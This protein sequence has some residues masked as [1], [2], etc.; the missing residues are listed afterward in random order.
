[1]KRATILAILLISSFTAFAQPDTTL[2]A[3]PEIRFEGFADIFYAYDFNKPTAGYRQPFLYNHNRHNEF[4]LNLALFKATLQ[5]NRYRGTIALQ[6]GTYAMDNY[7]S[8][9]DL[10]KHV[11]EANAG[12]ALDRQARVWLDAGIM[13][14][15][16]GFESAISADNLTLTRSLL[17][18]NSPYYLAGAK[19]S[20]NP[21]PTW[22]L[23]ALVVNGWQRI[24]RVPGN[25]LPSFGTQINYAP[26][27]NLTFNWS[28]FIGT[29]DP[30]D[31]RRMRYFN[32]L[33]GQFGLNERT[34]LIAGF[35]IG[36]QEQIIGGS[37]Y[38]VWYS[39][40]VIAH[41]KLGETWAVAGRAEYY[42]DRNEVIIPAR[43]INGF[44]ATGLS[45]NA[46]YTPYPRL[47]CRLEARWLKS[48]D[49]IFEKGNSYTDRNFV[50][51]SSIAIR[52]K[53]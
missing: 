15:H 22:T 42:S 38:D 9:E 33:F 46:D 53:K 26:N 13:G 32:N 5:H 30:D 7:A 25:S 34:T 4:N 40:V 31:I 37:R 10:L 23:A 48:Q 24:R 41:Y 35:D 49:D 52:L 44:R 6:A 50:L 28:T 2:S 45:A 3:D 43:G 51:V 19:V 1:M 8:E 27:D 14:S 20:Y 29:D 47:A 39:P 16:I 17:A 11:F 12:I 18:E 36:I 21:I